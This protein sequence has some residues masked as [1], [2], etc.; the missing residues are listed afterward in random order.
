M[1]V[2][3]KSHT[4]DTADF[5]ETSLDEIHIASA[6]KKTSWLGTYS[7]LTKY[8]FPSFRD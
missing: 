7:F 4:E 5:K 2:I 8:V 3:D 1:D 6:G